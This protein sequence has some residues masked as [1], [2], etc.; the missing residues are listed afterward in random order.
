MPSETTPIDPKEQLDE[1][2]RDACSVVPVPKSQY[3]KR[4]QAYSAA[5][6]IAA[7]EGLKE[8]YQKTGWIGC[9][10]AI[11]AAIAAHVGKE[12]RDE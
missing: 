5:Q 6:T 1:L 4:L 7:L 2:V 8:G 11:D 12:E 10:Y 3:R 9:T